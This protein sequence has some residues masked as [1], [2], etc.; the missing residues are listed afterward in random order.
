MAG[1]QE[2]I[3]KLF[4]RDSLVEIVGR[5]PNIKSPA[6]DFLYPEA[7]RINH[8]LPII[9]YRDLAPRSGNIPLVKR[10]AQ[11]YQITEGSG[12]AAIEPQPVNPSS[13]LD[14]VDLNNLLSFEGRT[15]GFA[16]QQT[17]V[18]NRIDTLRRLCR[19]TAQALAIQSVSGAINYAI[20]A[21]GGAFL[22][23]TIDFGTPAAVACPKLFDAEGVKIGTLIA[24]INAMKAKLQEQGFGNDVV[25]LAPADVY[26]AIVD[27]FPASWRPEYDTEGLLVLAPGLK[28]ALFSYTY[29]DHQSAASKGLTAKKLVAWDRGA[30]STLIY[31]AVDD[32]DADF[33]AS[34]FWAKAV[35]SD[36]PSGYKVIGQSKPIPVPNVKGIAVSTVIS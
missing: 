27:V 14:A 28:V 18:A 32:I 8:P 15:G 12:M 29:F 4:S 19:D 33:V 31:A 6:L 23:F 24:Q 5:L 20:R 36:D 25:F 34:P 16:N 11:S 30:G 26:A 17:I 7:N 2:L 21:D 1:T 3:R 22:P 9:S 13:F 35:K 10:G